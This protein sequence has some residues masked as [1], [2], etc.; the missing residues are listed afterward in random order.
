MHYISTRGA[1]A[2]TGFADVLLEGLAP[3]GG[4]YVPATW[5]SFSLDELRGF[6]DLPY[7][8]VAARVL[9]R[10]AGEDFEAD[11][12]RQITAEAYAS[13]A[14]PAVA[15]LRQLDVGLWML[16]LHHGP[17]LAFK[18]VAMQ[19][20]S[21]LY[22]ALLKRRNR[23]LTIVCAT[24]GDTGGAAVEAFR[25][26]RHARIIALFPEGRISEV[27]RRF[28]TTPT[29]ANV[30]AVA[31]DGAFDDCQAIV[32]ALFADADFRNEVD[33][34]GVNSINWAR[35]AAQAVYYFTSAVALGGPEIIPRFVT[36]TGNFGD[37][38][39]G[40]VAHRMGLPIQ[41]IV[42]ATN[43]NDILARALETG[44]YSR[45]PVIATQSP[46]MDIQV[47]SNFERLYFEA[48]RRDGLE[49]ARAFR[50]F[51]AEGAID[52]PP[53]ARSFMADLFA[54]AAVGEADTTRTL[55]A[56]LNQMG[57]QVD[58]HTAVGLAVAA[59][60][61]RHPGDGPTVVLSTAHPAK[62]PEA[63]QAAFGAPP[64]L[65]VKSRGLFD[66]PERIDRLP[67]DVEAVKTYVRAFARG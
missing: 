5:P 45:G 26:A 8:E 35:I 22:D 50:A 56:T 43:G 31:V 60:L 1:S 54:G 51:G 13:F 30:R 23:V 39:A 49:T 65:N 61:K 48:V 36:P 44:R 19:L 66:K 64:A 32:K 53:Q 15:P 62:F 63:A 37:A 12:L 42:A 27:Q 11:T 10:F 20:L 46:A 33:L 25:G 52:L 41:Q 7:A 16:E 58:P 55:V 6:R 17:T 2:P 34:S 47:A 3:D 38:F 21:R 57:E 9:A 24:S 29:D 18:D 40:Y 4:L 28:M 67:A 59:R 14:H